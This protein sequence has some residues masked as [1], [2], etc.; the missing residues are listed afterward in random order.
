VAHNGNDWYFSGA[1]DSRWNDDLLNTLK[2]VES[3]DFEAVNTGATVKE[4]TAQANVVAS[5]AATKL[6]W[7]RLNSPSPTQTV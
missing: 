6:T 2:N 5:T 4:K 1:P 7:F 3:S